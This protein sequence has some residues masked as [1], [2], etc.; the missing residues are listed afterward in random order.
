MPME[1]TKVLSVMANDYVDELLRNAR[2]YIADRGLS[3]VYIPDK[4]TRIPF[5]VIFKLNM[6]I[7]CNYGAKY[8]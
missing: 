4:D 1:H 2:R 6:L 3:Q 7:I 8:Y 5:K